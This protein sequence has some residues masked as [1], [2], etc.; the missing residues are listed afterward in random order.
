MVVLVLGVIKVWNGGCWLSDWSILPFFLF[1]FCYLNFE[2]WNLNFD[3][4]FFKFWFLF[5]YLWT[6]N[7]CLKYNVYEILFELVVD[8]WDV[9][10]SVAF[11]G[12]LLIYDCCAEFGWLIIYACILNS[13]CFVQMSILKTEN[14]LNWTKS[15]SVRFGSVRLT[16]KKWTNW[17]I[18][19]I[20][21]LAQFNWFFIQNR[22][23]T[24]RKYPYAA[25]HLA[26]HVSNCFPS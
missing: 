1:F 22:T 9:G 10:F 13:D 7:P 16:Y 18:F 23:E 25:Y 26:L 6:Y 3:L 8:S 24:N 15:N 4:Y 17:L 14:W 20:N 2:I 19:C 12:F 5:F 11:G 21:W